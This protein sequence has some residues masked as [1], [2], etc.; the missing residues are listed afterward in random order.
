MKQ[1]TLGDFQILLT[2]TPEPLTDVDDVLARAIEDVVDQKLQSLFAGSFEYMYVASIEQV[3][4]LEAGQGRRMGRRRTLSETTSTSVIFN[5]GVVAFDTD[6]VVD[7][8]AIIKTTIEED[9]RASLV[10]HG[11]PWSLVE[12]VFFTDL[13]PMSTGSPSLSPTLARTLAPTHIPSVLPTLAPTATPVVP[14]TDVAPTFAPTVASTLNTV[15]AP[16]VL[17]SNVPPS[18]RPTEEPTLSPVVP[19]LDDASNFQ[20]ETMQ[21]QAAKSN[22]ND[23]TQQILGAFF[24]VAFVLLAALMYARLSRRKGQQLED[25]AIALNQAQYKGS[26]SDDNNNNYNYP[27]SMAPHELDLD[28]AAVAR[29]GPRR[30][31]ITDEDQSEMAQ[32]A[33]E[34][35]D[36]I[37]VTSEWTVASSN[38]NN[39]DDAT[40]ARLGGNTGGNGGKGGQS[41]VASLLSSYPHIPS[42]RVAAMG[43]ASSETF[44]RDRRVTLQKDLLQSEW[45]SLPVGRSPSPIVTSDSPLVMMRKPSPPSHV[46]RSTNH[47]ESE[48]APAVN[49]GG[50]GG[51]QGEE[52]YLMPQS[53]GAPRSRNALHDTTSRAIV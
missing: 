38:V 25:V 42:S 12:Q 2:P 20:G 29:G 22:S 27:E 45:T 40:V 47:Y 33:T 52:V 15:T 51:N 17:S 44:E 8:R 6:P 21:S 4:V 11:P 24:G 39:G 48:G 19:R 23:S 31:Y 36:S 35:L 30:D 10:R 53:G 43:Y 32:Y 7:V 26:F 28:A 16:V 9:L 34:L 18:I 1:Y 50:S 5:G 37:S 14:P 13:E 49:G 3:D 46:V 41:S